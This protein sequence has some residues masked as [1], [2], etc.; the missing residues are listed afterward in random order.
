MLRGKIY[1]HFTEWTRKN[2]SR[3]LFFHKDLRI[4]ALVKIR[5]SN[6]FSCEF[7]EVFKNT[8]LIRRNRWLLLHRKKLKN[9]LSY[10]LQSSFPS[11]KKINNILCI[12][13]LPHVTVHNH[14]FS[15]EMY[16]ILPVYD[17]VLCAERS[18]KETTNCKVLALRTL[19]ESHVKN[20]LWFSSLMLL[21]L[22]EKDI[23]H[24]F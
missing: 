15:Q 11:L 12:F 2:L 22:V 19:T 7:F 4:G 5:H 9:A 21:N 8:F 17:T 6:I 24:F 1:K 10:F 16:F 14:K 3:S 18:K 13:S 23:A 20:R